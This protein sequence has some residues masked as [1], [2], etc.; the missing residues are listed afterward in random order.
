MKFKELSQMSETELQEKLKQL[1]MDVI[2]GNAQVATGTAP[3]SPGQLK[4]AKKTIARIKSLLKNKM[5][6]KINE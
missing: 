2:K 6:E 3:K 5:E 4:K 1:R